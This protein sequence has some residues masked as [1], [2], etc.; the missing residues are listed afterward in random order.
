MGEWDGIEL[1]YIPQCAVCKQ[2]DGLGCKAFQTKKRD[3]KYYDSRNDN[4]SKCEHFQMDEESP[5]AEMF[6]KLSKSYKWKK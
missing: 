4:F 6:L 1:A 2:C 5:Q 3:S